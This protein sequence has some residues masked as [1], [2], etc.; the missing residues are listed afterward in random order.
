[1]LPTKYW[2]IW[3]N[4]KKEENCFSEEINQLETRI[5]CGGHVFKRIGTNCT[6]FIDN[7]P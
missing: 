4:G 7:L 1:M 3:Q 2:F 5:A 6:I